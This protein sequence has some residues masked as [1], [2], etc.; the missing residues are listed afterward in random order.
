L[1]R[2]QSKLLKQPA[3]AARV[4]WKRAKAYISYCTGNG[5]SNLP[6]AITLFLTHRCNLRCKMCGQWGESG[7]TKT[8]AQDFI[9]EEMYFSQLKNIVS[10]FSSFKP[11]ITLFG[12]EPLLYA[13]CIDLI[14][15]IKERKMHCLMIT[16]GSL[17]HGVADK[18][19]A[20]GLDELNVSLDGAGELHD[21]IRGMPGLFLKI[22]TGL[23]TLRNISRAKGLKKPLINLQCTI[24]KYNYEKLEQLTG[25]AADIGADSL[26]YHNLIFLGQDLIENQKAYDRQLGCTSDDWQG[27]VFTPDI[28]PEKLYAKMEKI[29]AGRYPFAVDFYPNLSLRGLKEYY[30]NSSYCPS[31]YPKRCLS[32]WIVAYVFPNGDVRPCLN[33]TYAYGNIRETPFRK[34]WN[35]DKAVAF[36]RLLKKNKI[37][38]VCVRCTEL[39]RY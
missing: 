32:P 18:L 33:S 23:K 27:F 34:V 31:E 39:Y 19:V 30:R 7:V 11:N 16:N 15:Y 21:Q 4:A 5:K 12:G 26:T 22:T 36:R 3:Y 28:D 10:D 9:K 24:T 17:V 25:V 13:H 8:K 20:S 1:R 6:E 14:R 38:P 35:N 37:F 29:L 2:F